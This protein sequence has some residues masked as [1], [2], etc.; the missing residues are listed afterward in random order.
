MGSKMMRDLDRMMRQEWDWSI[1][2]PVETGLSIARC[3]INEE[4]SVFM[5]ID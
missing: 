1:K 5:V 3:V 4:E 2:I